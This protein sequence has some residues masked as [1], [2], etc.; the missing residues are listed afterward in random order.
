MLEREKKDYNITL[1]LEIRNGR[2]NVAEV[3]ATK[4]ASYKPIFFKNQES[5]S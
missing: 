5:S 4:I 1:P 2:D 3:D